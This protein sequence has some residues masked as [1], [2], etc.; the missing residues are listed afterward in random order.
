MAANNNGEHIPN[1]RLRQARL[2]QGWSQQELADLLGTTPVNISRW[3][4]GVI[5]PSPY[6]RQRLSEA[7]GKSPDAL[8]LTRDP[9]IE[10]IPIARN[11]YFT[12][13]EH[14]LALLH[15]RLS[16]R[17]EAA[18]TQAQTLYGLGGI[19][20][21]QTAAEYAYR[22][23]HEYT[24]VFW[25][26]A[27]SRDSLI[28][29]MLTLA[30]MLN[31]PK[32][33]ESQQP[34]IIEAVKR[35]LAGHD[36]WL[37]IMDNA[38]DLRLAREFLPLNH[39]GYILYT[40]RAQASGAIAAS[41]AVERLS[42]RDGTLL[43]LRWTKHLPDDLSLDEVPGE[44]RAAAELI[45]ETMDGLPLAIV[46]AAAYMEETG[47]TPADY[48]RLYETHHKDL[49]VRRSH[50]VLDYPQSVAAT[51]S[52]SFELVEQ[53][54]PAA[55]SVLRLCAF[56]A[57]DAIPEELLARG[58]AAL[59]ELP[60]AGVS[61]PYQLNEALEV[62][63]RYSLVRR[64]AHAHTLSIHPLV[65]TVLKDSLDQQAQRAWAERTVRVVS[66][67]FPVTGQPTGANR[68][69]YLPHIQQCS[70]LIEQHH[71]YFPE[72]GRLLFQ[73][74]A[75]LYYSGFHPQ[76]ESLHRQALAVRAHSLGLEHPDLAE[77][78][79]ALG[80]L[81]RLKGDY[82]QAEKF[83]QRA[84]AIRENSLDP[85]HP[86]TAESLNNLSVLY[87]AQGKYE[88]AEPLLQQA[89][90]IRERV[91]GSENPDTLLTFINLA[92]LYLEQ[93]KHEQAEQLLKKTLATSERVLEPE[94]PLI[95]LNLNLLGRLYF[96]QANYEL[97]QSLWKRSL[98]IL[99]K[100]LGSEHPAIAERLNDLAELSFAQGCYSEARSLCQR[101]ID[102]CE[103]RLGSQHP[104][105]IAYREHLA[106]IVSKIEAE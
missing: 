13:R 94:H 89:L 90:A 1:L 81:A 45:V 24:H 49:L 11:P 77:S 72:A 64:D 37:L 92:N 106:T 88:L 48:L 47:C 74:A 105:T 54:N 61:D 35:W 59:G 79:N 56:L 12:G 21:T 15:E 95:A 27:A 23:G 63:R 75:F 93:R 52:V 55:A 8:G 97:A 76:S 9:R 80:I 85:D 18:L 17:R 86:A 19:G 65:Q 91:L 43:L 84:L 40:T 38:D 42:R 4:N 46:Q 10:H 60:G 78:L 33:E 50:L 44:D 32:K 70:S 73:A 36:D 57:A 101:A 22:Y 102:I 2:D 39:K 58:A 14:L 5:F 7:F 6:F 71:L 62:L 30:H 69:A 98:T 31:L 53:Q 100:T 26:Q 25:V 96:T 103:K 83:H 66:A 51:W 82:G 29:G 41:I 99:E 3:E 20:K 104:D 87:R 28:A 67:A 16:T 68:Q 34:R